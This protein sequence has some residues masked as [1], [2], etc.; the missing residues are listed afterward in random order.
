MLV[1]V[2]GAGAGAVSWPCTLWRQGV[3]A[4][5]VRWLCA[6]LRRRCWSGAD[7]AAGCARSRDRVSVLLPVGGCRCRWW[8]QVPVQAL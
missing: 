5:V 1:P 6:L 4:D 7:V 2:L 3:G 8:V